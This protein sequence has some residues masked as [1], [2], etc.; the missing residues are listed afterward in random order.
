MWFTSIKGMSSPKAN[1]LAKEVP[2]SNEP[3]NPGP[4]VKAMADSSFLS[5]FAL[6]KAWCTTGTIFC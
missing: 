5:I 2:T 6:A 4:R 1:D 3:I